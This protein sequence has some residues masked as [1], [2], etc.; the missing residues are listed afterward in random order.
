MESEGERNAFVNSLELWVRDEVV[1]ETAQECEKEMELE[2]RTLRQQNESLQER[3][4]SL[5]ATETKIDEMERKRDEM[6]WEL[7]GSNV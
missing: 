4:K 6:V 1:K 7:A 2:M 5:S 3:I